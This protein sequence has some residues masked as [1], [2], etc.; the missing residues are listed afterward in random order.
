[1]KTFSLK[2][3]TF[4][5]LI[6][7]MTLSSCLK[8]KQDDY[9]QAEK[10][11]LHKYLTDNNITVSPTASGLYYLP[12]TEGTG[13]SPADGEYVDFDYTL[14][15][16]DG[17]E[18]VITT[19]SV[20][21]KENKIYSSGL[22]YGPER[23]MIGTNIDGLDEGLKKMMPGGEATMIVPSSLA[24]GDNPYSPVGSYSTV[25]IKAKLHRTLPDPGFYE[26]TLIQQY[27]ADSSIM[28]DSTNSG[29]YIIQDI[30][31]STDTTNL[32]KLIIM[33][34]KG[35][36]MDGRVFLPERTVRTV[37]NTNK[38][39]LITNGLIDGLKN[40]TIGEKATILVPYYRGYLSTGKYSD[41]G[42]TLIPIPPF[43]ALKYEVTVS[44]N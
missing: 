35:T 17:E 6:L 21:A 44:E 26:Q 25:I 30:A 27:L 23:L 2:I 31:G 33:T 29:V 19:D 18:V 43:S 37:I 16:L 14:T 40:M 32:D 13:A 41:D 42:L 3:L 4:L 5:L 12:E 1:M 36:L 39:S 15:R 11:K 7:S 20:V 34:L 8:N 9:I 24:W 22:I 38:T 28:V 10:D